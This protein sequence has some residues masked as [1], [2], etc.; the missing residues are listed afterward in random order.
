MNVLDSE[1]LANH[2]IPES[3]VGRDSQ[4]CAAEHNYDSWSSL[5]IVRELPN[6]RLVERVPGAAPMLFVPLGCTSRRNG[7]SRKLKELQ[8]K[9]HP[10]DADVLKALSPYR[11][12]H[13]NRLG[14]YLLDLQRRV[15]PLDLSIDSLF[16]SAT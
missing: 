15:P 8:G 13:F 12:E 6:L 4:L 14:D 1:D 3:R 10:A 2:V 9:G 7:M 11:C 5:D 16:K